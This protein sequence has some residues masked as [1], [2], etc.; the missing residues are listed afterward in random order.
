[1]N[2][3]ANCVHVTLEGLAIGVIFAKGDA[4]GNAAIKISFAFAVVSHVIP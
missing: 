2:L 1:L 3:I 4:S